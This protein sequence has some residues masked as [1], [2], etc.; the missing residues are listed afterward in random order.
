MGCGMG[1][2]L[3]GATKKNKGGRP[4]LQIGQKA[5]IMPVSLPLQSF[6]SIKADA[7][8]MSM[9]RSALLEFCYQFW[10]RQFDKL[11]PER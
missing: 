3:V 7:E 8:F 6:L 11:K 1:K 10:K 9:S 5:V 4:P 2:K